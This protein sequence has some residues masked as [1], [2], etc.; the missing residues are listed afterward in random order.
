[1]QLTIFDYMPQAERDM[2]ICS[3]LFETGRKPRMVSGQVR[4]LP[5]KVMER[6]QAEPIPVEQVA[7]EDVCLEQTPEDS[8]P[9]SSQSV[10]QAEQ[11]ESSLAKYNPPAN[12]N[13]QPCHYCG[14][15]MAFKAWDILTYKLQPILKFE[16]SNDH[17]MN[18]Y[19]PCLDRNRSDSSV[20]DDKGCV[21]VWHIGSGNSLQT[22]WTTSAEWMRTAWENVRAEAKAAEAPTPEIDV[23]ALESEAAE[24]RAK[25]Q[26]VK[27]IRAKQKQVEE[28]KNTR[29]QISKKISEIMGRG[30]SR[31]NDEEAAHFQKKYDRASQAIRALEDEIPGIIP[32][33]WRWE[34]RLAEI[35]KLLGKG[36]QS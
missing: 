32:A 8:T 27:T 22:H 30:H 35:E 10:I 2:V 14:E 19:P 15:E 7:V 17:W 13:Q 9:I 24:L 28:L 1:M 4:M 20:A 6:I 18:F 21:T 11:E 5:Q 3:N 31:L 29:A 34:E 26:D 16:C 25:L 12:D 33:T 36:G 23:Q